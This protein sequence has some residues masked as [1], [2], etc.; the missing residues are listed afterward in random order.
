MYTF[1]QPK[2]SVAQEEANIQEFIDGEYE[3]IEQEEHNYYKQIEEDYYK[4]LME[5]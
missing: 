2:I 5:D 4:N 1:F 3:Y